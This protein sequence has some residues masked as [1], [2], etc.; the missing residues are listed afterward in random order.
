MIIKLLLCSPVVKRAKKAFKAG[1]I[2]PSKSRAYPSD[3]FY[4]YDLKKL[5]QIQTLQLI[6]AAASVER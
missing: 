1:L 3:P 6:F 4:G 5:C 2:L